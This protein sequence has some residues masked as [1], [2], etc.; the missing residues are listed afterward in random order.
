MANSITPQDILTFWFEEISEKHW[1][2]GSK[3][4]DET[5]ESRFGEYLPSA[6]LGE[7]W[8]WRVTPQGRLAEILMLDQFTRQI[9]RGSARA[10][11]SDT[12]AVA[13]A[14][15]AVQAKAHLALEPRRRK[16]LIMPFMHCESLVIHDW[17]LPLWEGLDDPDSMKFEL[18][19]RK[20]IERFGRYPTRNTV[21]GRIS[22]DEEI[23]YLSEE[24]KGAV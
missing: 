23:R 13:L 22:T 2:V 11:A 17:S 1:W 14:Q 4:F 6:E 15:E 12:M 20:V 21:L 24:Q 16:F 5:V 9:Y 3:A 19:H 18:G 8:H 10:Y 7:F